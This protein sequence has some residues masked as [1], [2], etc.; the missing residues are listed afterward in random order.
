MGI[1]L[2][3]NRHVRINAWGEGQNVGGCTYGDAPLL[4]TRRQAERLPPT[5]QPALAQQPLHD[6]GVITTTIEV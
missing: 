6:L 3:D 4:G 2:V 5:K 1:K